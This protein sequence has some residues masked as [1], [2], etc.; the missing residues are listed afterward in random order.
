M[1]SSGTSTVRD[2]AANF[3]DLKVG[4]IEW[5]IGKDRDV[6]LGTLFRFGRRVVQHLILRVSRKIFTCLTLILLLL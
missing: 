4:A 5:G 3:Q 2:T 6:L 1:S